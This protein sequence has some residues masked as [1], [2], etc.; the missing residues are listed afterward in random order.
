MVASTLCHRLA[1]SGGKFA[2][3]TAKISSTLSTRAVT[4]LAAAV[5]SS[6]DPLD[7]SAIAGSRHRLVAKRV[8]SCRLQ[9]ALYLVCGLCH[10]LASSFRLAIMFFMCWY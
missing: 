9:S 10:I 7:L 4:M 3:S 6:S 5:R 8:Y 1:K 2:F